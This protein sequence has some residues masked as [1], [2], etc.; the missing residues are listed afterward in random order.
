MIIIELKKAGT[1]TITFDVTT[2]DKVVHKMRFHVT[3][4]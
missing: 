3:V 4:T 1:T 2:T